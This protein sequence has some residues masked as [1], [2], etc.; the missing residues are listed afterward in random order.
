MNYLIDFDNNATENDISAYLASYNCQVLKEYDHFEKVFL[1]NSNQIPEKT[2]IVLHVIN[3]DETSLKLLGHTINY[4]NQNF[5]VVDEKNWWKTYSCL[6]VDFEKTVIEF[7]KKGEKTT[8]Y[9]LD[10]GIDKSHPEFVNSNIVE[11]YSVVDNFNDQTGHGT[12]IASLISGQTCGMTNSKLAICKIFDTSHDTKQSELLTAFDKV[13]TDINQNPNFAAVVNLSWSI[14]KNSFVDDKIRFLTLKGVAVVAAAGNSGQPISDVT[15]AWLNEVITVGSYNQNFEPCDFSDYTD[16]SI[17]LTNNI[18]NHGELDG[19]APGEKIWV[20]IPGGGYGFAAGTSMSA[21]IHSC[22]I[23][24]NFG[25]FFFNDQLVPCVDLADSNFVK[26]MSFRREGILNFTDPKYNNSRNIIT[27]M[28]NIPRKS[29]IGTNMKLPVV[30]GQTGCSRI[31]DPSVVAGIE[32]VGELNTGFELDNGWLIGKPPT[33][34]NL[35]YIVKKA[36]LKITLKDTNE[37][38]EVSLFTTILKEDFNKNNYPQD[39][40]DIEFTF[41]ATCGSIICI[42]T[43]PNCPAGTGCP[44]GPPLYLCDCA[45]LKGNPCGCVT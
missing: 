25:D 28:D 13:I 24:Y 38:V 29:I 8:V 43:P 19:W 35:P 34:I 32:L 31:Y 18:T 45:A 10:S 30:V 26:L 14:P 23:A 21:A 3:D 40:P 37:V 15:P 2:S 33:S 44:S 41:L 7:P 42:E 22:A 17:S 9:I 16:S 4:Q 12:A 6:N 11:L 39:D 36:T 27:T 20:A 1:V 5:D